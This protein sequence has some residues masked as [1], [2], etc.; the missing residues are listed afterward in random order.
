MAKCG[1]LLL[2][3]QCLD[4]FTPCLRRHVSQFL[5]S[6]FAGVIPEVQLTET[7]QTLIADVS[8]DLKEYIEAM[9]AVKVRCPLR[10][11]G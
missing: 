5:K 3:T 10:K 1:A 8:K 4:V 9:D 6:K 11:M 7:E 2:A